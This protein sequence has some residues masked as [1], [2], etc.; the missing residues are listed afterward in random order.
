[1]LAPE[2]DF[3]QVL[4]PEAVFVRSAS[5]RGGLSFGI[6]VFVLNI[7]FSSLTFRFGLRLLQVIIYRLCSRFLSVR[8]YSV[9]QHLG[10]R[11]L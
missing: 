6:Y 7:Y 11:K 2:A 5:P 9:R 3:K 1:M 8:I 4:A 10:R